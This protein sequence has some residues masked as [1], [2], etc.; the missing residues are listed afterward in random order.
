MRAFFRHALTQELPLKVISLLLAV[1]LFLVVRS[2]REGA[3]GLF[4]K[5][6]YQLPKDRVLVSDPVSEVRVGIRGAWARLSHLDEREIEPIVVDLSKLSEPLVYFHE[7]M[8]RLPAGLRAVSIAPAEV[9]LQYESRVEKSVPVVPV[10][11]GQPAEGYRVNRVVAQPQEVRIEGAR[12]A[13]LALKS[14]AT[15]PLRVVDATGPVRSLVGFEAPPPHV[16]Y[17]DRQTVLVEGDVQ[18]TIL[19]ETFSNVPVKVTGASRLQ[20]IIEPA[21]V[22]VI[23]RGPSALL[24]RVVKEA[25]TA[26]IDMRLE[27]SRPHGRYRKR[28]QVADL[29]AGLAAEVRPDA[30]VLSTR[31]HQD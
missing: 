22:Q 6:V 1:T 11:E 29:P 19:E 17:L 4:V 16:H 7:E 10:V 28:V 14:V 31:P 30:V 25:V 9:R 23:L 3:T 24:R 13:V 12:S 20:G 26:T 27:D 2:D 8:V 21:V 18:P 5:V 15:K